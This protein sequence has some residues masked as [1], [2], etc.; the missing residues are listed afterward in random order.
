MS[1]GGGSRS[2]DPAVV[3][4]EYTSEDRFLARRLAAQAEP[5]GP[6]VEDAAI[7]AVRTA[8]PERV[9]EVGC[10]TGDFTEQVRRELGVELVAV[11][12][13]PRM[14]ELTCARGTDARVADIQ[15]LP[16]GA[17]EFDCV[18][19]NRVLYHLPDLDL[20]LAEIARVLCAGGT[21]VAVTYSDRHL[22]ELYEML[23]RFPAPSSFSAE[24]GA[25]SLGRHFRTVTRHDVT[26]SARF[27]SLDAVVTL[28][29]AHEE[30]GYFTDVDVRGRLSAVRF[31]YTATYRHALFVATQPDRL[32][33]SVRTKK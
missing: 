28:L 8:A 30:F 12:M 13:S 25:R 4:R 15:A 19:A 23:G 24:N 26:G 14:V 1:I 9:L 6:L 20:G 17:G 27:A 21:L 5:T 10:G 29:D 32:H 33:A 18:L 3:A 7:A 22:A 11:D 2:N 16:F 31:P